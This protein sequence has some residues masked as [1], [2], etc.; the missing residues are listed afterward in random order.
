MM[1]KRRLL[2]GI[3]IAVGVIIFGAGVIVVASSSGLSGLKGDGPMVGVVRITSVI[4]G[5]TARQGIAALRH[6]RKDEDIAA[7]VLRIDTPGGMVG[8]S[9]EL[10][11]EVERTRKVKP[12]VA[13]MG[14]VAASGG[15]YIAAA[16]DKIVASPGTIT[17]SIGV[18]SQTTQVNELLAMAHIETNTF[19]SGKFKDTGSPL[20]VMRE[21][22]KTYMQD[23]ILEIHRQFVADVAKGRKL[24]K[25][26]VMKVADGRILPGKVAKDHKLVDRLGN[27]SDALELSAKLAKA[28]EGEP[29]PVVYKPRKSLMAQLLEESFNTMAQQ[30]RASLRPS[31]TVEVRE[32]SLGIPN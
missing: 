20:R 29:V 18:I 9:Q 15:Y 2:Y 32:P 7:V 21:D 8:P 12:V 16:C 31:T 19:K 5:K 25:A 14:G 4:T 23:L 17:G 26:K 11:R 27:Y 24:S 22:E 1:K 28:E 6:F 3:L 30:L 13:S 10:Y